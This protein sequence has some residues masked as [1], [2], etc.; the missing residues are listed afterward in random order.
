MSD[1]TGSV[2][3]S[4]GY[5]HAP[6][7]PYPIPVEDA[8]VGLLWVCGVPPF[9]PMTSYASP[10]KSPKEDV[11]TNAGCRFLTTWRVSVETHN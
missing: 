11:G 1:E 5:R 7:H 6:E 10:R 2:V 8:Y 9:D 3:V 4:V